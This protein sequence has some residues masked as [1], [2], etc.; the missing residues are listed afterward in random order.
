MTTISEQKKRRKSYQQQNKQSR[1]RIEQRKQWF[2]GA[3]DAVHEIYAEMVSTIGSH[4]CEGLWKKILAVA[5]MKN[6]GAPSL[7]GGFIFRI[8]YSPSEADF[9]ADVET[10]IKS[11]LTKGEFE[12]YNETAFDLYEP[13]KIKIGKEL[14]RRK[15]YPMHVY[16]TK[17]KDKCPTQL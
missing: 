14:V 11:T 13:V 15:I 12:E 3:Y 16:F 9:A 10:A 17:S 6:I 2:I 4:S 7:S 8:D 5:D 1:R